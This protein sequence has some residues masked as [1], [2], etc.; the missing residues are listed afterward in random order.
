MSQQRETVLIFGLQIGVDWPTEPLLYPLVEKALFALPFL[1]EFSVDQETNAPFFY[2]RV[3]GKSSWN[4]PR[5]DEY[6]TLLKEL[7]EDFRAGKDEMEALIDQYLPRVAIHVDEESAEVKS[8]VVNLSQLDSLVYKGVKSAF[9]GRFKTLLV[10]D[11]EDIAMDHFLSD[12]HFT[13]VVLDARKMHLDRNSRGMS[14]RDILEEARRSLVHSMMQGKVLVVALGNVCVDFLGTF[15]DD[16]CTEEELP[17]HIPYERSQDGVQLAY[18]P[19]EFLLEAGG[20]LRDHTWCERLYR[21]KELIHEHGKKVNLSRP[22]PKMF[23]C[24]AR[25]RVM[26]TT[27]IDKRRLTES[28]FNGSVGLP[29][30]NNFEIVTLSEDHSVPEEGAAIAKLKKAGQ[31]IMALS[32]I[33][34]EAKEA[35]HRLKEEVDEI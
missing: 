31:G 5:R 26:I 33:S 9:S 21:R 23:T 29:D 11:P 12:P 3:Q 25:F 17:R 15:R 10:V 18:L 4:H 22:D 1:F 19:P 8:D 30:S 32:R 14:L 34:H 20:L 7:R 6:R 24:H 2:D 16:K 35:K 13:Y 28:L 27:S